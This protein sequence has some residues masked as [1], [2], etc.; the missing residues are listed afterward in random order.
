MD[1]AGNGR[2]GLRP[3]LT[4]SLADTVSREYGLSTGE[5]IDLGGSANLNLL[6]HGDGAPVVVR[7]YRRHVGPGRLAA[8]QRTRTHLAAQ[9]IPCVRPIAT[10]EGLPYVRADGHLVE[11][12][13]FVECD[14]KMDSLGGITAALP[15]LG[16]LHQALSGFAPGQSGMDI[17]FA[18]YVDPTGLLAA[19]RKGTTRIRSWQPTSEEIAIADAADRLADAV[20]GASQSLGEV[21][22]QLTHGD[23]WDNNVGFRRGDLVLVA[24]F[25]FMGERSRVDDLAL[26]LYFTTHLLDSPLTRS[27]LRRLAGL[28]DAYN[29]GLTDRL[30]GPERACIPVALACQPLWSIAGWV[31]LLDDTAEARRHIAGHLP[32]LRRGEA[33]LGD[34]ARIQDIFR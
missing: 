17:E 21:P 34:L 10:Q 28:V 26:T 32:A 9:G 24:D 7:V 25:D 29:S 3:R 1:D 30:S 20:T 19:T 12:E 8:I 33:I 4:P 16:R 11:V 27:G 15:T 5:S 23:F 14:A 22:R 2:R 18:N 31:A 13:P 6:V